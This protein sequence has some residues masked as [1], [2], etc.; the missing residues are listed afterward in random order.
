MWEECVCVCVIGKCSLEVYFR[1]FL[2]NSEIQMSFLN[3]F[4]DI[5]TYSRFYTLHTI[6]INLLKLLTFGYNSYGLT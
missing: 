3:E 5:I 2:E 4:T 1:K 6:R